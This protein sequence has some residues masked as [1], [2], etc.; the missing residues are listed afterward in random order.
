MFTEPIPFSEVVTQT[1]SQGQ[2]LQ[3]LQESF[4]EKG[5]SVGN[6]NPRTFQPFFFNLTAIN[7][8]C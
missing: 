3:A 5:D 7:Y 1:A 6:K 8:C 4:R 2:A